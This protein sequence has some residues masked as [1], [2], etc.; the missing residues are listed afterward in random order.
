MQIRIPLSRQKFI[1]ITIIFF[2]A[3]LTLNSHMTRFIFNRTFF[4]SNDILTYLKMS[5]IKAVA[6]GYLMI[7]YFNIP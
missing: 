3:F 7:F 6:S 1:L 5:K 4:G 2:F